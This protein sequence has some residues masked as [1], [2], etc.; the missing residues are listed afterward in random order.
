MVNCNVIG[1]QLQSFNLAKDLFQ[2]HIENN[3]EHKKKIC[4]IGNGWSSYYLSK[5][6]D[7]KKYLFKIISP[8][9]KILNTPKLVKYINEDVDIEFEN[10]NVPIINDVVLDIN[11]K[12]NKI[13]TQNNIIKY[14]YVVL[15]IGSEYNDFNIEGV[16]KY[17]MKLK[18]KDDILKLKKRIMNESN[19]KK[20]CIIGSGATGIELASKLKSMNYNID[21]IEGLDNILP[22][23]ND[24]TKTEI[25]NY[26]KDNQINLNLKNFVKKI[27]SQK[28]YTNEKEFNYDLVI[29]TGGIKFSGF[30]KTILFNSLYKIKEIKPRGINVNDDFS[31][32]NN[33]NIFC[34]GDI[35]ANK[36]PPTAQNAKY[37]AIWLADYFNNNFDS[38]WLKKN[39]FK[40]KELGKIL[41]LNDKL[42]IES[43]FYSGYLNKIFDYIINLFI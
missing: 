21:I 10:K 27:D 13:Y 37:Q 1:L 15:C 42:Y 31:I 19:I 32:N 24:I 6:L 36:G 40:E 17:A 33:K 14:D 25:K 22:G 8:N 3:H 5:H 2:R 26:L 9:E 23:F 43:N 29:W 38:D 11:E 41:H 28:I 34:L 12:Y 39:E 35:V 20:I 7:K 4:I 16:D 18:N 30:K